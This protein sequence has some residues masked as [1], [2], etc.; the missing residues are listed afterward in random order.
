MDPAGARRAARRRRA[1][2]GAWLLA[3]SEA[4]GSAARCAA[5]RR[6]LVRG[7]AELRSMLWALRHG[8]RPVTRTRA[9][10][11]E[12]VGDALDLLGHQAAPRPVR[13]G[14]RPRRGGRADGRGTHGR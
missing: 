2:A 14:V 9:P 7:Q 5:L 13:R 12:P 3:E 1:L 10:E 6:N 11:T 4:R 8:E